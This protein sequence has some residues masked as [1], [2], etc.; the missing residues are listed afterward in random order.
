MKGKRE[1][2]R[3]VTGNSAVKC[4]IRTHTG[5]AFCNR[6]WNRDR[7]V[8]AA[9]DRIL[10]SGGGAGGSRFATITKRQEI[11]PGR[12]KG[13]FLPLLWKEKMETG[14]AEGGGQ[15]SPKGEKGKEGESR[16]RKRREGSRGR[17]MGRG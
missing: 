13:P 5:L 10:C 15:E 6:E 16:R 4:L 7:T 2:G 3:A 8:G 9:E 11:G 14:G 17:G 12:R 1:G